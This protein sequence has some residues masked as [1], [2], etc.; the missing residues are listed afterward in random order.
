MILPEEWL[1]GSGLVPPNQKLLVGIPKESTH[2]GAH[3]RDTGH[4][5]KS[6]IEDI[7]YKQLT[8]MLTNSQTVF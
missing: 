1:I 7:G 8:Q 6:W 5:K 3:K 4:L 2:V